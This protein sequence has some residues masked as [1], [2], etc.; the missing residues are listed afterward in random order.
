MND[1]HRAATASVR[2]PAPARCDVRRRARVR[3]DRSLGPRLVG[4]AVADARDAD[5]NRR[6]QLCHLPRGKRAVAALAPASSG[7]GT[8]SRHGPDLGVDDVV[9]SHC[10][11]HDR[12]CDLDAAVADGVYHRNRRQNRHSLYAGHLCRRVRSDGRNAA[13]ISARSDARGR[14]RC[15]PWRLAVHPLGPTV[16]FLRAGRPARAA[17]CEDDRLGVRRQHERRDRAAA[18]QLR[19]RPG[20]GVWAKPPRE[21]MFH[22]PG[23]AAD[24]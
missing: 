16:V 4:R 19:Q 18:G 3:A 12:I 11:R 23:S 10:L 6:H 13:S 5:G 15:G 22:L 17:A 21:K 7:A 8:L 14:V 1:S 9:A 20:Q 2:H 24:S